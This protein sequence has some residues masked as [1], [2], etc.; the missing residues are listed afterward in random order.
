MKDETEESEELDQLAR[1]KMSDDT[2]DEHGDVFEDSSAGGSDDS[3]ES[4][5]SLKKR[6]STKVQRRGSFEEDSTRKFTHSV[7]NDLVLV[8]PLQNGQDRFCRLLEDRD[9]RRRSLGQSGI[10]GFWEALRDVSQSHDGVVNV[11]DGEDVVGSGHGS[12]DIS[13]DLSEE[14][15]AS[16]L[17]RRREERRRVGDARRRNEIVGS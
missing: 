6:E 1:L 17:R 8:H 2:L 5:S 7:S 16:S 15:V 12:L 14:R 10:G 9:P 13:G 3:S 4:E 11:E